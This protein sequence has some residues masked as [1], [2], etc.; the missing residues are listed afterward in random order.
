MRTEVTDDVEESL[1]PFLELMFHVPWLRR[2][3][4]GDDA[5]ETTRLMRWPLTWM[6]LGR[7]S[8]QAT[9]KPRVTSASVQSPMKRLLWD[10]SASV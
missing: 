8:A 4:K 5:F 7:Q 9:M 10:T 3:V 2:E 6:S 1:V